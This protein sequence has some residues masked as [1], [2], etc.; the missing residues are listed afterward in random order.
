MIR[1]KLFGGSLPECFASVGLSLCT[2]FPIMTTESR[3]RAIVR[4]VMDADPP[5]LR[6]FLVFI[7]I[8]RTALA[9]PDPS[10]PCA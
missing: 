8:L 9:G 4:P 7:F 10:R 5:P 1:T 2:L 3:S 6:P